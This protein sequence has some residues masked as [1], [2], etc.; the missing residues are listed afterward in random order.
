VHRFDTR[1]GTLDNDGGHDGVRSPWSHL[2]QTPRTLA[3]LVADK[4]VRDTL[5][6]VEHV[7]RSS[8]MVVWKV[9]RSQDN[10]V[11]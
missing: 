4:D 10:S 2:L 3:K 11:G 8:R 9:V 7:H 5:V 6:G 1:P